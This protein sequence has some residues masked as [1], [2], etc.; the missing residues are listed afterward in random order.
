MWRRCSEDLNCIMMYR[1]AAAF[2]HIAHPDDQFGAEV[3]GCRRC[4]QKRTDPAP[5]Y[6]PERHKYPVP[7]PDLWKEDSDPW[8][9]DPEL[10][11]LRA[12]I[13]AR[14][15]ALFVKPDGS[16]LP[17]DECYPPDDNWADRLTSA[18]AIRVGQNG[19]RWS[20]TGLTPL[21]W[22]ACGWRRL[23]VWNTLLGMKRLREMGRHPRAVT[24][25]ANGG[26]G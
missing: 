2:E 10:A 18:S 5:V 6:D 23:G 14:Y 26:S 16:L 25:N 13:D 17:V 8:K 4:E 11:R 20:G 15:A 3:K 7:N 22:P 12:A 19:T 1:C 24:S 9:D 21:C